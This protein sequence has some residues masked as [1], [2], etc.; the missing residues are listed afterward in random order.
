MAMSMDGTTE[1]SANC[2]IN[3]MNPTSTRSSLLVETTGLTFVTG[4]Q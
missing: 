3:G 4:D 2:W 1:I